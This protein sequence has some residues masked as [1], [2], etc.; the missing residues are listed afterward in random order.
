MKSSLASTTVSIRDQNFLKGRM[1][2]S[3]SMSAITSRDFGP[4]GGHG[5]I[6]D[7]SLKYAPHSASSVL[8]WLCGRAKLLAQLHEFDTVPQYFVAKD[9]TGDGP[10]FNECRKL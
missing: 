9:D 5:V 4:E 2:T 1:T 8:F 7:L 6:Y 10:L 3:L